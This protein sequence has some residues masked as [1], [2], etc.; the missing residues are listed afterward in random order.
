M[1]AAGRSFVLV[2]ASVC[3]H[4]GGA[5][6]PPPGPGPGAREDSPSPSPILDWP[7]LFGP[8]GD[9]VAPDQ[10]L[11]LDWPNDAPTLL[12]SLRVGEGYSSPVVVGRRLIL[13][14]R[15]E[16]EEV[17]DAVDVQTRHRLW[18]FAYPTSYQDRYGYNNGPRSTPIAADGF[19]YTLGAEG[20]MHCL[21]LETGERVW[22]RDLNGDYRVPQEFFGV[23][24]SPLLEG[25]RLIVNVGGVEAGA[26]VV[27]IDRAD[28]RTIWTATSHGPSYATPVAATAH[29]VRHAVVFT[30][31]GL[32]S[33]DP[34][35]GR[36]RWSIPFRS[37]LYESVNASSPIAVGDLVFASASY[38]TGAICIRLKPDGGFEELWRGTRSMESH[39]SN[40]MPLDGFV[41]GFSGRHEGDA[42]LRCVELST[43]AVRWS[44]P[45][46]LGRGSMVRA[47]DRFLL[48][49]ERGHLLVR[50]LGP[51]APPDLPQDFAEAPALL[52]YPCWTPPVVAGSRLYLRNENTLV[53]YDLQRKPRD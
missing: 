12:W 46:I 45:S 40:L 24:A 50:R 3:L 36:A 42:E 19:V 22:S 52:R 8:T 26:G 38:G 20:K 18:R 25:G 51:D 4:A 17:V 41:Y 47:S 37:R 7:K 29:G 33:L 15:L 43:G 6:A 27:A 5:A 13:F 1:L 35:E 34:G 32:V 28:G 48:W 10:P 39:F 9:G 31:D 14:H 53:C 44:A 2:V 21:R 30:K 23:G 49:G 11:D 16:D